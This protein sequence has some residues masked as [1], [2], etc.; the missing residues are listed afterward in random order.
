MKKKTLYGDFAQACYAGTIGNTMAAQLCAYI[1]DATTTIG[2][3]DVLYRYTTV[4]SKVQALRSKG[5]LER[6]NDLC[7]GVV[8][9]MFAS[10]PDV[11]EAADNILGF[12][13]DLPKDLTDSVCLML[14]N[15]AQK[16][17]AMEYLMQFNIEIQGREAWERIQGGLDTNHK[18]ISDALNGSAK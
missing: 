9:L 7:T 13:E 15:E 3:D 8:E 18:A 5:E 6:L 1:K 11:A 10:T 2:A 16:N 14:K 17:H 4:Q 12:M